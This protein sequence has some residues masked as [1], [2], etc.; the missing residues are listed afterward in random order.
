MS[1]DFAIRT[2]N[3]GKCYQIYEKPVDRLKQSFWRWRKQFYR[4]FWALKDVSLDI[5]KGETLGIVGSNG[6]GKSTLL[7]L[8]CN[9]LTP[10]IGKIEIKGKIAALLELGAGFNLEFTGRENI[11]INAAITGL[12]PEE[13][14]AC[15][16]KIVEFADIGDF[17]DQPVKTYSSG[18][19]VRLAFAIAINVSPDILLI[20]EA[21][22]VGDARFR[23]KCMAKIKEF[24]I[25]GTVVFVS[26]DP[27]AITELCTRA[28]WIESGKIQMD[29][30]PK[31]VLEK[32]LQYVCEGEL[33]QSCGSPEN[34]PAITA[35]L[36]TIGFAPV[37][38]DIRQ[39]GDNRVSIQAVRMLSR[40]NKNGVV[41]SGFSCEISII[42][43]CYHN[44]SNPIA[45]FIVKDRLGR[46]VLA[47][48]NARM[49]KD[50]PEFLKGQSYIIKFKIDEWPNLIGG[51]YTLS[52]AVA[53]GNL[54]DYVQCHFL[55]DVLI[56][57]S[58]HVREPGG[59]FSVLKTDVSAFMVDR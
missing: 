43:N 28:L 50:L 5:K 58:I 17:I 57:R 21:L 15:Y 45:G 46:K 23:Q 19:Y 25:K 7:Q 3:L 18:M 53:D 9:I 13:I 59:I 6:S 44:I 32:Y 10:T 33:K 26:H 35:D 14:D 2:R 22:A 4:E 39:F 34:Q 40:N 27:D 20:D 11:N 56:F 1:S 48:N 12:T 29:G 37:S 38:K 41:Y 30:L 49:K 54:N 16:D 42:L 55:H 51:D 52:V 8:L 31:L 36:D 47:D 24:C